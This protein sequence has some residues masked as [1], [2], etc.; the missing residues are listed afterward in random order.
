[1]NRLVIAIGRAVLFAAAMM[2]AASEAAPVDKDRECLIPS[3]ALADTASPAMLRQGRRQVDAYF[4]CV[5]P[6]IAELTHK[7]SIE[8]SRGAS[9]LAARRDALAA[10]RARVEADWERFS[11][12]SV[13]NSRRR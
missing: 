10:E 5:D 13:P 2:P 8:Q 3:F 9:A 4:A 6:I 11:G 7:I 1:M 12:A